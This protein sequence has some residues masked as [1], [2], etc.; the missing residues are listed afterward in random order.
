MKLDPVRRDSRLAMKEVEERNAGDTRSS[1]DARDA[2]GVAHL[3]APVRGRAQR[4]KRRRSLG[5]HRL[6]PYPQDVV[7]VE[8]SF[9]AVESDGS[10]D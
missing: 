2:P 10:S 8:I 5:D 7:V 4:A 6:R 9:G 1:A 3:L